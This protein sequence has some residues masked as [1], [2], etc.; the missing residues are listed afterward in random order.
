MDYLATSEKAKTSPSSHQRAR[1]RVF[2]AD[3]IRN[4]RASTR[5]KAS[6]FADQSPFES[7]QD[8]GHASYSMPFLSYTPSPRPDK[9]IDTVISPVPSERRSLA[10]SLDESSPEIPLR[11][12]L[13]S[14]SP[15][16]GEN[17]STLE[18]RSTETTNSPLAISAPIS[19]SAPRASVLLVDD[20]AVNLRL[21]SAFVQKQKRIFNLAEDGA[22]AV[23]RY[24]SAVPSVVAESRKLSKDFVAYDIVFMDLNMPVL[25]G[26]EATRR[27][28]GFE[29]EIGLKPAKIIAL[30]GMGTEDAQKEAFASGVDM[31]LTKPVRLKEI[32]AL[33]DDSQSG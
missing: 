14:T 19:D 26:L 28:R 20:N 17:A 3:S 6:P 8:S 10:R 4:E 23:D 22:Q 12:D 25:G 27:I 16:E 7:L 33:L 5:D 1:S 18:T 32:A 29:R 13:Q 24:R 30:T 11:G 9:S 31:F 21:L 15:L 2:P